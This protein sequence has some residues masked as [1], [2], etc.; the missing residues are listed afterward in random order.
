MGTASVLAAV[1]VEAEV[2]VAP[3]IGKLISIQTVVIRHAPW[4]GIPVG[5]ILV[6]DKCGIEVFS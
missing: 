4:K 2:G 5:R 3:Y 1:V 6:N